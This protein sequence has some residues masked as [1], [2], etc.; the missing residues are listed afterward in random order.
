MTELLRP[1]LYGAYHHIAPVTAGD[2]DISLETEW[3]IVGP[4]C[5][6]GDFLGLSRPLP[7][8]Q[9]GDLLAVYS[10]GAYGAVLGSSYNTRPAAPE[11]LVDGDRFEIVRQRPAYD[12]MLDG[13]SVPDWL[14]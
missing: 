13:E 6:S 3:D 12:A 5:E 8:L 10:V 1:T 9:T 14:S 4:V 2:R 7:D 11:V